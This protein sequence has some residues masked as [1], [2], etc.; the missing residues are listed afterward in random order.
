MPTTI[1]VRPHADGRWAVELGE[2]PNVLSLHGDATAASFEAGR[3]ALQQD[4]EVI[5]HDRYSCTHVLRPAVSHGKVPSP[6]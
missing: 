4:A 1:H 6:R 3:R 5:V 2:T